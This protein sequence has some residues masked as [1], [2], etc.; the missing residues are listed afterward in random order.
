MNIEELAIKY[1]AQKRWVQTAISADVIIFTAKQLQAFADEWLA[2]NSIEAFGYW[3]TG[4]TEE[5]SDFFIAEHSGDVSCPDCIKLYKANPIN[6]ALLESHKRL[7]EALLNIRDKEQ[8]IVDLPQPYMKVSRTYPILT[9]TYKKVA[10]NALSSIPE[11]VK[12]LK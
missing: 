5:E 10:A 3:H 6:Q 7:E 12:E 8:K 4:E 11:S 1:G 2:F 9:F